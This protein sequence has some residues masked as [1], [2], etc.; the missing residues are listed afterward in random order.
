MTEL[1]MKR[2]ERIIRYALKEDIWTGDVTS[3]SVIDPSTNIDAVVLLKENAVVCGINVAEKVFSVV[4]ED[5]KFRPLVKDGEKGEKGKEIC[6]VEGPCQSIM[7]A[8]RTALNFL[9]FLS[10][11]STFTSKMVESVK[12]TGAMIYDTRKT[13]PLHRY[14]EKYA[15]RVGGGYNHRW[16]LWDMVLIKDNHIKSFALQNKSRNDENII[17]SIIR[18]AKEEVQKNIKIE[19]EVESLK[20]CKYALTE[21]PDRIMLDNMSI[22]DIEKA[23]LLRKEMGLE[24]KVSF[25]VSGGIT[26]DNV[27]SYAETGVDIISS[28]DLTS[29]IS[30]IDYSMEVILNYD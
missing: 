30:S 28:G 2:V 8:E 29:S 1:N 16:G 4:D 14:L 9:G 27:K 13:I 25:E 19:I 10:A 26:L 11:I 15:V 17:K 6:Y 7:R 18:E 20:E 3:E 21:G 23:I 24:D 5:I 22:D 12:D